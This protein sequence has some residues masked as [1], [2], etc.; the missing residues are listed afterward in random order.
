VKEWNGQKSNPLS[1]GYDLAIIAS[2]HDYV[3]LALIGDTPV[4]NTQNS[5]E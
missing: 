1:K 2:H 4:I 5:I 3:N